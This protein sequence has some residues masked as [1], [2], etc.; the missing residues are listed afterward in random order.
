MGLQLARS[1]YMTVKF[2]GVDLSIMSPTPKPSNRRATTIKTI[3]IILAM[4]VS[5]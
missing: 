5:D 4:A 2:L 3:I 1:R